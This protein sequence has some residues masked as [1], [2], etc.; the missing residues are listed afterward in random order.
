MLEGIEFINKELFW[1]LLCIPLAILWYVFKYE[2][3]TAEFKISSIKGFKVG[4][5]WLPKLKTSYVCVS[6]TGPDP[7]NHRSCHARKQLMYRQKRKP[8]GA[9]ILLW[10]SM[11]QRVCWR[12]DLKTKSFRGTKERGRREFIKGRPNDR[13][14]LGG[15]CRRK[16]YQNT[17]HKR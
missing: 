14:G 11:Y 8:P 4:N 13:I 17:Y 5:S 12:K 15:I 2:K 3:Q 16:L 1:A 6:T 9:L 7:V 10:P